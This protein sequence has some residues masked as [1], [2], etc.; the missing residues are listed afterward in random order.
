L[1]DKIYQIQT[2]DRDVVL[3]EINTQL[4]IQESSVSLIETTFQFIKNNHEKYFFFTNTSLPKRSL[5][6]IFKNL[7]LGKYFMELL[8]YDT[9]SKKENIEYVMQVHDT[10]LEDILFIDDKQSHIDAVQNT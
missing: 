8:C 2:F 7:N 1:L 5:D 9:G 10:K 6:M 3:S 4:L